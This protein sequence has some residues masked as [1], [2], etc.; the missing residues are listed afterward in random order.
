[1]LIYHNKGAALVC[2][3]AAALSDV[4]G[5]LRGLEEGEVGGP[6]Q[7]SGAAQ[8]WKRRRATSIAGLR[9]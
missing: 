8:A 7:D 5:V 9:W 3:F 2:G 4:D 6:V 1:V